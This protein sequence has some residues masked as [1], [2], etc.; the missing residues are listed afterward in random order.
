M[1]TILL[2]SL[3]LT[4]AAPTVA[5]PTVGIGLSISFGGG[6][7]QTGI[8]FRVFS[9]DQE[10]E[11]VGSVGLDYMFGSQSLRGTVGAAYLSDNSFVGLDL[12]YGLGS[13]AFDFGV[14]AGGAKTSAPATEKEED[15]LQIIQCSTECD[16]R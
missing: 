5:D 4:L 7:P 2:S 15:E 11:V 14:S 8:A 10:E 16:L 6:A 12:G 1:R 13:G 9:D 3:F